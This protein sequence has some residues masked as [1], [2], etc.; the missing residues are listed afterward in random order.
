[1][2]Q[3]RRLIGGTGASL[4]RVG[5]PR[6]ILRVESERADDAERELNLYCPVA[7]NLPSTLTSF[8]DRGGEHTVVARVRGRGGSGNLSPRGEGD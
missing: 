5:A 1:M 4:A 7:E 2:D 3:R 6:D 8:A